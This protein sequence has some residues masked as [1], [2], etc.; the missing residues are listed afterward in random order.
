MNLPESASDR[1]FCAE[2]LRRLE[3]GDSPSDAVNDLAVELHAAD[4]MAGATL[5][6]Y[7]HELGVLY[8]KHVR[9]QFRGWSWSMQRVRRPVAASR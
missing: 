7:Q 9:D 5:Q 6:M 8:R 2:L 3:R 4:R 1:E